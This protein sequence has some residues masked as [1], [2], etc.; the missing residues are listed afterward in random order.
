MS[1]MKNEFKANAYNGQ[2]TFIID[3][4]QESGAPGKIISTESPVEHKL[5]QG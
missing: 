3:K 1:F 2:N 4:N 5:T